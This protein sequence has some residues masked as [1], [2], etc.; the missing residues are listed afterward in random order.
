MRRGDFTAPSASGHELASGKHNYRIPLSWYVEALRALR[1][2]PARNVRVLVFS[3]GE[4][5]EL[6]EV[7]AEPETR[8]VRAGSAISQMLTMA[9]A[10]VLVAS[11]S[12]FSMWGAYLGQVPSVWYPGQRRES[13][14]ASDDGFELQPEWATGPLPVRFLREVG[15]RMR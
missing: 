8:L 9:E 11:G 1:A 3:D 7:L 12:T 5:H 6:R 14:L 15:M 10:S 13:V 4:E 2:G